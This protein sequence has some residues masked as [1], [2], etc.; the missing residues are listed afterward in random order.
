MFRILGLLVK[1]DCASCAKKVLKKN[2]LYLFC[3]DYSEA[4]DNYKR[5][6]KIN[7]SNDENKN[8]PYKIE[9]LNID[10]TV[11]AIVGKNGDGK[12]SLVE[13][14]LRVI[15]NFAYTHGFRYDQNTLGYNI[16]VDATLYYEIKGIQYAIVCDKGS[17]RVKWYKNGRLIRNKIPTDSENQKEKKFILA[18]HHI[19]NLFYTLAINYSL[20]AYNSKILGRESESNNWIDGL[21]YKNDAYQTPIGITPFRENG[22]IDVNKEEYLSQQRLMSLYVMAGSNNEKRRIS[23]DKIAVGFAFTFEQESKLVYSTILEYFNEYYDTEY[24][25]YDILAIQYEIDNSKKE[26]NKNK[27]GSLKEAKARASMFCE[28]LFEFIDNYYQP[29][30]INSALCDI[31]S[32]YTHNP[33][34]KHA[35]NTDFGKVIT[36]AHGMIDFLGTIDDEHKQKLDFLHQSNWTK[37]NYAQLYRLVLIYKVW[38]HLRKLCS[39]GKLDVIDC[40]FCDALNYRH[41]PIY[42]AKLY[43]CYKILEIINTY[44]PYKNRNYTSDSKHEIMKGHQAESIFF[45]RMREDINEILA[46]DDYTVLKLRQTINYIQR[47]RKYFDAIDYVVDD[48]ECKYVTFESLSSQFSNISE[49]A[50]DVKQIILYLPPPIFYGKIVVQSNDDERFFISDMSSGELQRLYSVGSFLYHLRNLDCRQ[51]GEGMINYENIL[52]IFEEIELYFHPEYQKTFLSYLLEQIKMLK[53]D[54]IKSI[55]LLFVTHSPF[56]LTDVLSKNTVYLRQGYQDKNVKESFGAN[57]YDLMY[58]SFFLT[59]NALGDCSSRYVT[60]LINRKNKGEIIKNE[61]YE[62]IGDPILRNYLQ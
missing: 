57:L 32:N 4:P 30:F 18:K 39:S 60:E 61:E 5:L 25:W 13:L 29:V 8:N 51:S 41:E 62:I 2:N 9:G 15:N 6:D 38:Q 17:S 54:N 44:I 40:S 19:R 10:V 55:N 58:D 49:Q 37:I 50:F 23:E 14:I 20:Y 26:S 28:E 33:N 42:A 27:E 22:N 16:S 31:V 52:L 21:F 56:I 11:N 1:E 7:S 36:F 43:V 12:S 35:D 48:C 3:R 24:E 47:K 53:L 46:K 59:E 34:V 45:G